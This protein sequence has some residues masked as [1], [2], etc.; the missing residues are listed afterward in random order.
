MRPGITG[1]CICAV[2]HQLRAGWAAEEIFTAEVNQF[3]GSPGGP[4]G[5]PLDRIDRGDV[6]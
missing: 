6:N 1:N 5:V 2:P 4:I 3:T